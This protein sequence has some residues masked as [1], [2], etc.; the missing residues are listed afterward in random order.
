MSSASKH[1]RAEKPEHLLETERPAVHIFL[2]HFARIAAAVPEPSRQGRPRAG[3]V[4][5]PDNVFCIDGAR[6]SGKT[7]TL[8]SIEKALEELSKLRKGEH[9]A[10][11]GFF[12]EPGCRSPELDQLIKGG[13]GQTLAHVLRIIFPGDME[14]SESLMECVFSA[15]M[16]KLSDSILPDGDQK[17]ELQATLRDEVAEGW[18]FAKRFGHEAII[19]DSIDYKDFVAR[20]EQ[21]SR[22]SSN[23]IPVW[24]RFLER[25]LDFFDSAV[26]VVLMDDSDVQ[27]RLAEDILHSIR[28]FMNH[29]RVCPV[30]A[31]NIRAMR[32]SLLH[33]AMERIS[34][35]V[36]AL[37]QE[38]PQTAQ[39]WR[40][41][42]RRSTEEYLEKVLPPA[43][44]FFLSSPRIRVP[45][46]KSDFGKMTGSEL[47]EIIERRFEATRPAFLNAKFSLAFGR[48]L[49]LHDQPS[50]EQHRDI[51]DFL[52]WWVF[53][54]R[55]AASLA[56][57]SARQIG[58][59]SYYYRGADARPD[60]PRPKRL[61]VMLHDVPDNYMLVQRLGDDDVNVASWLRQ[62]ELNSIWV[63]QRKFSINK[64]ETNQ[65]SY[66]YE[67]IC[68]RIDVG[69][70]MPLRDNAEEAVPLGLLPRMLGRRSMRRFFQPRNMSK[71][72]RRTGI[73]RRL[74]HSAI[75][76]NCIYFSDLAALPD[77]SLISPADKSL[78]T[79][80]QGQWEASLFGR[81]NEILDEAKDELLFRYFTEV[82]CRALRNTDNIT[83][84]SLTA[85]LDPSDIDLKLF[86][87]LYESSLGSEISLFANKPELGPI[88]GPEVINWELLETTREAWTAEKAVEEPP[89]SKA[90]ADRRTAAKRLI[91]LYAALVTD[92]RRAWHAIRIHE[93]APAWLEQ[94][95][96]TSPEYERTSRAWIDSQ[97]RMPLY[98]RDM[99]V[100]VF[101]KAPWIKNLFQLFD[102]RSLENAL[103]TALKRKADRNKL[104]TRLTKLFDVEAAGRI[105]NQQSREED[106]DYLYWRN[107]LRAVGRSFRKDWPVYGKGKSEE[108]NEGDLYLRD[109]Q[110]ED[111]LKNAAM[112]DWALDISA[113][114]PSEDQKKYARQARN[115][116]L[117]LNG[118]APSLPAI[119][120]ANVMSRVYEAELIRSL[121]VGQQPPND[122]DQA[123]QKRI[124]RLFASALE[125]IKEWMKLI[126]V[127]TVS[128]RYINIKSRHL[129]MN[130]LLNAITNDK[131]RAVPKDD[132]LL[133]FMEA[134]DFKRRGY[135][136]DVFL[137]LKEVFKADK[138]ANLL[139]MMPD[140]SPETLFGEKWIS[141]LVRTPIIRDELAKRAVVLDEKQRERDFEELDEAKKARGMFGETEKWLW[142][143]TRC[144]RKLHTVIEDRSTYRDGVAPAI[145]VVKTGTAS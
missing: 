18:Y 30:L 98:T 31:G 139:A 101:T 122:P 118:L 12:R 35:S 6:G 127:L 137:S 80:R 53:A 83:S 144:L 65:G 2:R 69:L 77:I 73:A 47:K 64:R 114:N 102:Q 132:Q 129:F 138:V 55:Y 125:D 72:E 20:Y 17:Q 29:P 11:E 34:T 49:G 59:F 48:E 54:N 142:A 93:K 46:G 91:A 56:P 136:K 117:L 134:C 94:T 78:R 90:T 1:F 8:L 21:E 133:Q 92:L 70:G 39:E 119:I 5:R 74:D 115:F 106:T 75:P 51:E 3:D 68:Y 9:T 107:T 38:N 99:L 26:L 19:R 62:Q 50:E 14:R 81:W 84:A 89:A 71:Q 43:Q 10:W 45:S 145:H 112:G 128:L 140:F 130:L 76:G 143:A 40:R 4:Q 82:V 25:Y 124:E 44:R 141:D 108:G 87:G 85:A 32:I 131:N 111:H 105:D 86:L 58:T 66:T 63:G 37:D 100:E 16:D 110:L 60:S 109:V 33:L 22:K 13:P 15:M 61:A 126:G 41:T 88:F 52:S 123:P 23:R 104:Q 57:R 95:V 67:Y 28:M 97:S 7:Y 113:A 36:K 120:H 79:K 27:P 42:E 116:V 103:E 121:T 24:R 96:V 135:V